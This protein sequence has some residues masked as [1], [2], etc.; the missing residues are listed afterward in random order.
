MEPTIYKPGAY[1]TPGI[2]KGA[3]GIYKGRGVYN[4]GA[5]LVDYKVIGGREYRTVIIGGVEWL[6][7]NLDLKFCDIG[8]AGTP[9]TP[10]A[11][12]Y[13]NNEA[14]YGIDGDKKC[15]LLYNWAAVKYLN[16]NRT[17]ICKGWRVP[18][19]DDWLNLAS[20][21][22]GVDVAGKKLKSKNYSISIY[23]PTDWNGTDDYNFSA[24]PGGTYYGVFN[25]FGIYGIFWTITESGNKSSRIF[26]RRDLNS[27]SYDNDYRT[28][29]DSLRLVRDL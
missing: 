10:N 14:Q 8:G 29:A 15:G 13:N 9:S 1:N 12:Y 18:T 11:W 26:F 5:E 20:F 24:L 2:Y 23:W 27:M 6:A 17:R 22:G 4:N 21:V 3:G 28:T 7:E 19:L 16:D 25:N